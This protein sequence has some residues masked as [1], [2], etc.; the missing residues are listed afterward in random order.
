MII[1][2]YILKSCKN[3]KEYMD[4]IQSLDKDM[5]GNDQQKCWIFLYVY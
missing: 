3:I 5:L 2:E 4:C 1:F